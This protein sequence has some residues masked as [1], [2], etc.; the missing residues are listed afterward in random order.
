MHGCHGVNVLLGQTEA[1][2]IVFGLGEITGTWHVLHHDGLR[3]FAEAIDAGDGNTLLPD[4]SEDIRFAA[5]IRERADIAAALTAYMQLDNLVAAL[6]IHVPGGPP[7]RQAFYAGNA[8]LEQFFHKLAEF[9]FELLIGIHSLLY[10]HVHLLLRRIHRQVRLVRL[11]VIVR[12]WCSGVGIQSW[13]ADLLERH[14]FLFR[15]IRSIQILPPGG[16]QSLIIQLVNSHHGMRHGLA[17]RHCVVITLGHHYVVGRHYVADYAVVMGHIT[18]LPGDFV[19][20]R[21]LALD[22]RAAWHPELPDGVL[23]HHVQNG[24]QLRP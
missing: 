16:D 12:G 5:Q 22:N 20:Y 14:T 8:A 1:L 15:Q 3:V 17:S 9:P 7:A 13:A 2:G 10:G 6:E 18:H 21:L 11:P 4:Q 24:L 23:G 19:A